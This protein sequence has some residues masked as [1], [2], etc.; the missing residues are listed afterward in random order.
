MGATPWAGSRIPLPATM[1]DSDELIVVDDVRDG[2]VP[3]S[4]SQQLGHQLVRWTGVGMVPRTI[5]IDDVVR[6]HAAARVVILGAG[7]DARA[8]RMAELASAI[9][10]LSWA[11]AE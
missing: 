9:E 1:L 7:L 3:A 11:S 5:A 8:W 4:R 2:G 10:A 6:G